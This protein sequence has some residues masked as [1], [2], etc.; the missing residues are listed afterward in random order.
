MSAPWAVAFRAASGVR[1]ERA[2]HAKGLTLSGTAEFHGGAGLGLPLLDLPGRYT[3]MFRFSR[4]VGLPDAV[5][6]FL[7]LAVRVVDAGGPGRHQDLLLDTGSS[8]PVLRR[9]PL[10]RRDLLGVTYSSL[11][12]FEVAR[13]R[14][15]I[16]AQPVGA[17]SCRTLQALPAAL[18]VRLRLLLARLPG[19]W[20]PLA[21]L[22][23]T[24][25]LP[26]PAGRQIRFS[27]QNCVSELA[28]VGRLNQWRRGAYS[29][30]HVGPDT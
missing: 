21:D 28:P 12:P 14:L 3:A 15:L 7:G 4:G 30:S 5:P 19:G 9:L 10:P 23:A 8:L 11:L 29:A 18:P 25:V 1:K 20:Q 6:D 27:P 13:R 26:T 16:G 22:V 17:V 24:D 2:I